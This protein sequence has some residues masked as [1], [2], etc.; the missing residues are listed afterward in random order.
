MVV[1]SILFGRIQFNC[2]FISAKMIVRAFSGSLLFVLVISP[3]NGPFA[4]RIDGKVDN[5]TG[6]P[7]NS[8]SGLNESNAD[9]SATFVSIFNKTGIALEN[10]RIPGTRGGEERTDPNI[11][12]DSDNRTGDKDM[13][14]SS[15]KS[16]SA[17][18]TDTRHGYTRDFDT[19]TAFLITSSLL[20]QQ[21][22]QTSHDEST[23]AADQDLRG[24]PREV[25]PGYSSVTS[26]SPYAS[27]KKNCTDCTTSSKAYNG[28][29]GAS[30]LESE[31]T[32]SNKQV[33]GTTEV[34]SVVADAAGKLV[35]RTGTRN[36]VLLSTA[37][38]AVGPAT[39]DFQAET[40]LDQTFGTA[41][42]D[43]VTQVT[44]DVRNWK[45][46]VNATT[47]TEVTK[48]ESSAYKSLWD[49]T[50]T[51][52]NKG[53]MEA[54]GGEVGRGSTRRKGM[55]G[56]TAEPGGTGKRVDGKRDDD[57]RFTIPAELRRARNRNGQLC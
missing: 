18:D 30:V 41:A 54:D 55:A 16:S 25:H 11:R 56:G 40:K 9:T 53:K 8:S 27:L 17:R 51:E 49:D 6:R 12:D 42:G 32:P 19:S 38:P 21:D 13:T 2:L 47:R 15:T 45:R 44:D 28:S 4:T 31:N 34:S 26:D 29:S 35:K 23:S 1:V 20:K 43:Q 14:K 36:L 48:V 33:A 39:P 46:D 7:T 50:D 52:D 24:K 5:S 3:P 57:G 10:G 22:H 37:A